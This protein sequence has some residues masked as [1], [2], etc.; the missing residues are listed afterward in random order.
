M[1]AR[2]LQIATLAGVLMLAQVAAAT[3]QDKPIPPP[4]AAPAPAEKPTPAQSAG[5]DRSFPGR[6]EDR[7][8]RPT[9]WPSRLAPSIENSHGCEFGTELPIATP[10]VRAVGWMARRRPH[11]QEFNT[12][13]LARTS[14]A[15][16]AEWTTRAS[17]SSS[18]SSSRSVV[19]DERQK[20]QA[21]SRSGVSFLSIH[22]QRGSEGQSDHAV[23]EEWRRDDW[24]RPG[25][26]ALPEPRAAVTTSKTSNLECH[27]IHRSVRLAIINEQHC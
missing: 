13:L 6:E 10:L 15:L 19:D 23:Q 1:S 26:A 21:A 8:A 5:R 7:A 2:P 16:F 27:L 11:P 4:K 12:V 9:H 14:T 18:P 24:S 3:A 25:V 22:E 17:R 20:L